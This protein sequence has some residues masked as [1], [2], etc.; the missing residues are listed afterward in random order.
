MKK[1]QGVS[2]I[3]GADGPTSMFVLHKKK[4]TLRQRLHRK[5]YDC[6]KAKI[7]KHILKNCNNI[8]TNSENSNDSG[9]N[10]HTL[11]DVCEYIVHRLGF[12][13]LDRNSS[14][15]QEEYVEMRA[16]YLIQYAPELLGDYANKPEL[17]G[18]SQEEIRTFMAEMDARQEAAKNISK[19]EFDIDL[20][21]YSKNI[22]GSKMQIVVE[23]RFGYIGGG[24]SGSNKVIKQF[25]KIFRDVYRYYGVTKEDII[26]KT[27]RYNELVRT[28]AQR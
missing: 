21:E 20:Y 4:L 9:S 19:E 12:T 17:K 8:D 6:R 27:Q 15:Y 3:G 7:E 26:N 1:A 2:I 28:L 23:K 5:I 14:E 10:S 22:D 24:A 25:N 18:K 13:E 16:S 11:D